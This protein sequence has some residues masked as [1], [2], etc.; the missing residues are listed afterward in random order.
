[1]KIYLNT[2]CKNEIDIIDEYINKHINEPRITGIYILDTGSTDGT[3]EKL[4]EYTKKYPNKLFVNQKTYTKFYFDVARN[5]ASAMLPKDDGWVLNVDIDEYVEWNDNDIEEITL[6]N[7]LK[8]ADELNCKKI[9]YLYLPDDTQP[10]FAFYAGKIVK[11]QTYKWINPVHELP[12][13]LNKN[14]MIF[15]INRV[16]I[17]Q[18]M[19]PNI[20]KT[21][22]SYLEECLFTRPEYEMALFYLL[23]EYYNSREF[24]KCPPLIEKIKKSSLENNYK[25][26]SLLI[27]HRIL[28]LLNTPPTLLLQNL[29]EAL[30]FGHGRREVYVDLMYF[31]DSQNMLID[32]LW[33]GLSALRIKDRPFDF[34]DSPEFWNPELVEKKVYDICQKIKN[35]KLLEIFMEDLKISFETLNNKE[36]VNDRENINV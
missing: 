29:R 6:E 23:K 5:D 7:I 4:L 28:A 14:D 31:Y 24:H 3:Y 16:L 15:K 1:M 18:K 20:H 13:L 33:A 10:N 21:Y 25:C 2:I 11:N 19:R 12:D 30:Y 27:Y 26:C 8:K 36:N 32:A 35:E 22:K 9:F 34:V 17:K